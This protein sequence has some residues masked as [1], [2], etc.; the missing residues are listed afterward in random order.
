MAKAPQTVKWA[1]GAEEPEDL[2]DFLSNDDIVKKNKKRGEVMWPAKGPHTFK[3]KRIA[4]KDNRNG[5]PR[6]SVMLI[7]DNPKKS[8]A[9]SWNGYLI[10]DGFNV[11]EQ[12]APFLKRFLKALGVEWSDFIKR[13]KAQ[14]DGDKQV[15]TQIGKVKFGGTKD[16]T[17]TLT[18]RVKPADDYN[19]DEHMEVARYLPV[20]DEPDEDV[21]DVDDVEE[22][23]DEDDGIESEEDDDDD[24]ED[25]DDED[26]EDEE[27]D[28][29]EEEDEEDEDEEDDDA[30]EELREEL[31]ALTIPNLKK[32]AIRVCK[33][34]K[35]DV[36][37]IPT[38]KAALVDYIVECEL[39][40]PPF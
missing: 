5:D 37:D 15:I 13:T 4:M 10:W 11:T 30:E 19:D 1:L 22:D 26:D 32:R 20:D 29:D 9:A 38:K 23:E 39:G 31:R 36:D 18:I 25:S 33:R 21:E 14:V 16:P 3:V 8:D 7:M 2:Q 40:E 24:D 27:E 35:G 12:G 28:D 17:V 34:L 6:I